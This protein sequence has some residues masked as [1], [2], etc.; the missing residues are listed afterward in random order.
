MSTH[1]PTKE[2]AREQRRWWVIDAEGIPLGRVASAVARLLAGKHKPDW[3]PFT[4]TGDHVVVVNCEKI[5][6][7]GKKLGDKI[8]RKHSGYPGGLSE[9]P[10]GDLL[11]KHPRRVVEKAVKGMLPKTRLGRAMG[12]KLRVHVGPDH[13]HAAQAPE[14]WS[15]QPDGQLAARS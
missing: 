13:P 9:T 14:V 4:D 2:A 12:K 7:T 3:T 10:A 1:F 8:Y 15:V 5:A 11:V 6:L